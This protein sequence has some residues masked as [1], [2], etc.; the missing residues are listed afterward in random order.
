MTFLGWKLKDG[1]VVKRS[2]T[3]GDENEEYRIGEHE[4]QRYRDITGY[5]GRM[6]PQYQR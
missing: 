1:T 3:F 2:F 4:A 6:T 5:R